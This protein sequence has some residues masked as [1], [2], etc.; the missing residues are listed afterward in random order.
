MAYLGAVDSSDAY[1]MFDVIL[2]HQIRHLR[3]RAEM[4]E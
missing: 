2:S 3:K 1:R 4:E